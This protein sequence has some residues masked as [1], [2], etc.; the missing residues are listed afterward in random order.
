[1]RKVL[2]NVKGITL[3][4]LIVT[5]IVILIISGIM[6]KMM[7]DNDGVLNKATN[8]KFMH[9]LGALREEIDLYVMNSEM[10]EI[11]GIEKYPVIKTETMNDLT[12]KEKENLPT[13]LKSQLAS[14]AAKD[15]EMQ[16]I[17]NIDYTKIYKIDSS[18]I[19]SAKL[20]RGDLY[21]LESLGEYK[22]ISVNGEVYYSAKGKDTINIIIP[23]N[24]IEDPKYITVANNTYKLYGDGRL[25]VIGEATQTKTG[26]TTEQNKIYEIQEF[27]LD[28][29][30]VKKV[31]ARSNSVKT[32]DKVAK[33]YGVQKIYFH[34]GT[35]YVIDA[36]GDLWAWGDNSFNKLGQGNSYLVTEPTKI[37]DGRTEGAT[38]VK[39]RNVWAG[40]TNTYVLDINNQLWACG[41]NVRGELGQGNANSYNNFVK[42]TVDG[43]DFNSVN[44]EKIELS[45]STQYGSAI[46]KCDNGKVYGCGY[47]AYGQF[48]LG[49][50]KNRLNFV[51]LGDF[52]DKWNNTDDIINEG[53]TTFVLKNST[54]YGCGYNQTHKVNSGNNSYINKLVEIETDVEKIAYYKDYRIRNYKKRWNHIFKKKWHYYKGYLCTGY[55]CTTWWN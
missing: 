28:N 18:K 20:F 43:L 5:I 23:L 24:N 25:K 26:L 31:I 36:N 37:L 40:A 44:I 55:R 39:A 49:D 34:T 1:M 2:E 7:T 14:L 45:L 16:T 46:I 32:D 27:N 52:D 35:A 17:E 33:T 48:G 51:N 54:L 19:A 22:V 50:N 41:T 30:D 47:N 53:I 12:D 8:A 38:G 42:V 6:I 11:E 15:G 13:K 10:E 4:A 29:I 9:N 3:I 21:L